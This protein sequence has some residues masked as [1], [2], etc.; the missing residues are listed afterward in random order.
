[1]YD[2]VVSTKNDFDGSTA[3]TVA[4]QVKRIRKDRGQSTRELSEECADLGMPS[5]TRNRISDLELGRLHSI[6]VAELLVL[7][8]ALDVA[9]VALLCPVGQQ[10]TAEIL[11]GQERN[12]FRAAQWVT[13]EGPFPG[14]SDD[15]YLIAI[16]TDWNHAHGG[17]LALY[18][19]YDQA[20]RDE[21]N[22][23]RRARQ[24]DER[25]AAADDELGREAYAS[26]AAALRQRAEDR[27]AARESVRREAERL[28]LLPPG[29]AG[30]GEG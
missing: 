1:M 24:L 6:T 12:A 16:N 17:A 3:A 19:S 7:A 11:P 22:A 28:G 5:L 18:R 30:T 14:V 2:F 9:P 13:G 21:G 20:V 25:A 27:R 23:L 4:A 10:E 26:A 8:R 29:E 15:D